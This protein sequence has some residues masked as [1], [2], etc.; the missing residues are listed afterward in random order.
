MFTLQGQLTT[1]PCKT[2]TLGLDIRCHHCVCICT[3]IEV[4]APN[5]KVIIESEGIKIKL[6]IKDLNGFY[7]YKE[8]YRKMLQ[9]QCDKEYKEWCDAV[10]EQLNR[11]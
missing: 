6:H 9:D 8:E 3:I 4:D 2:Y 10:Q 7:P 1:T 11:I 5:D